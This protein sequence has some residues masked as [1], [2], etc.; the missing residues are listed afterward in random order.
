MLNSQNYQQIRARVNDFRNGLFPNFMTKTYFARWFT[1]FS[2]LMPANLAMGGY[3]AKLG[4]LFYG[5]SIMPSMALALAMPFLLK[6][7]FHSNSASSVANLYR[8]APVFGV[9]ILGGL[10]LDSLY[11]S[12]EDVAG[13]FASKKEE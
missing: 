10:L 5:I 6:G 3:E 12:L 1:I 4:P 11:P 8:W 7:A 2:V 13:I 9:V